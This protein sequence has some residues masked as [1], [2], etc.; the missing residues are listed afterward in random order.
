MREGWTMARGNCHGTRHAAKGDHT[1]STEFLGFS[2]A[3]AVRSSGCGIDVVCFFHFSM[4]RISI[5]IQFTSPC[6][7]FHAGLFDK[8][9]L[10][11]LGPPSVLAKS[12]VC[13]SRHWT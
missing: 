8:F 13:G 7:P 6:V 3:H 12:W 5:Y 11:V 4:F 2:S 9:S 10:E 1:Q